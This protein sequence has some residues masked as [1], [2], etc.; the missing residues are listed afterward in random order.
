MSQP[1]FVMAPV[2]RASPDSVYRAVATREGIRG[3][4]SR[5][6]DFDDRQGSVARIRF[7]QNGFFAHMRV[8]ELDAPRRVRWE[9]VESE[10]P[11]GVSNDPHDWV[12]TEIV[13]EIEPIDRRHTRLLFTHVG[14][15][16]LEC[17]DVCSD[18]WSFYIDHSLRGLVEQ[19]TGEPATR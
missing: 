2:F 15:R 4:W 7:P 10:H 12:G 17:H 14:L 18:I 13:F 1:D 8:T 9:C 11:P 19:G 3:W 6:T 16:P 5:F